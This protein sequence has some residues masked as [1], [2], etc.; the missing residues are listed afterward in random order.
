MY[1]VGR[2]GGR[3]HS[4]GCFNYTRT[5]DSWG[6]GLPDPWGSEGRRGAASVVTSGALYSRDTMEAREQ[7]KGEYAG[8][9]RRERMSGG[10]TLRGANLQRAYSRSSTSGLPLG[11]SA[12]TA[13]VTDFQK[14]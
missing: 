1:A 2:G 6:I 5:L 13:S 12:S 4:V 3:Q 8:E 14:Q 11:R 10:R 9:Q 7:V